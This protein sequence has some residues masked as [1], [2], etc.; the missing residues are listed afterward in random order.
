L[1]AAPAPV[2]LVA[3]AIDGASR[4]SDGKTCTFTVTSVACDL[5]VETRCVKPSMSYSYV[6]TIPLGAVLLGR[7]KAVTNA[8]G[9]AGSHGFEFKT[10][11]PFETKTEDGTVSTGTDGVFAFGSTKADR[12]RAQAIVKALPE[13]KKACAK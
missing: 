10:A 4:T 3:K 12:A 2:T 9:F 6:M 5:A 11:T 1:A 8:G 13:A 7:S